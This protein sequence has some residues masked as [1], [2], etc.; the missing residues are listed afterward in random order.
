MTFI[1][2][3]MIYKICCAVCWAHPGPGRAGLPGPHVFCRPG[4]PGRKYQEQFL[5][6]RCGTQLTG[7]RGVLRGDRG[8]RAPGLIVSGVET[9]EGGK[10]KGGGQDLDAGARSPLLILLDAWCIAKEYAESP[11]LSRNARGEV[12]LRAGCLI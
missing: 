8:E 5:Q 6:A 10:G 3:T 2:S 12:T 4:C 11:E 7:R 1:L 9:H